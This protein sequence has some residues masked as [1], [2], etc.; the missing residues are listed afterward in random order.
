VGLVGSILF[1]FGYVVVLQQTGEV[2]PDVSTFLTYIGIGL[3]LG[4]I[5]PS[6]I[7]V[8]TV[9]RMNRAIGNAEAR[10]LERRSGTSTPIS[11]PERTEAAPPA[12]TDSEIPDVQAGGG[13]QDPDGSD[14][15]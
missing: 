15:Q 2:F 4:V 3:V 10:L 8:V 1:G 9:L 12:P 14:G 5:V 6:L 13:Q 7:R 11:Q